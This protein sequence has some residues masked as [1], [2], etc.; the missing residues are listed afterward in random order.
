MKK[1]NFKKLSAQIMAGMLS[2]LMIGCNPTSTGKEEEST[3]EPKET[4]I[5]TQT[6]SRTEE[7]TF[8]I[9]HGSAY[10]HKVIGIQVRQDSLMTI[11]KVEKPNSHATVDVHFTDSGVPS[12][13]PESYSCEPKE[14][15]VEK[16][17]TLVTYKAGNLTYQTVFFAEPYEGGHFVKFGEDSKK[18]AVCSYFINSQGQVVLRGMRSFS[19]DFMIVYEDI[20]HFK[21]E[22]PTEVWI[23]RQPIVIPTGKKRI[24]TDLYGTDPKKWTDGEPAMEEIFDRS[25]FTDWEYETLAEG[26]TLPTKE[27]DTELETET[28]TESETETETETETESE[29]ETETEEETKVVAKVEPNAAPTEVPKPT[30]APTPVPKP[31]EAPK[32][33]AVPTPVPAPTATPVPTEAPKPTAV[34]TP[35]P[36]PVVVSNDPVELVDQEQAFMALVNA[37]RVARGKAPYVWDE[38]LYRVA[39]VRANELTTDF[40]HTSKFF[41]GNGNYHACLRSGMENIHMNEGIADNK[42]A[43]WAYKEMMASPGHEGV[44][45]AGDYSYAAVAIILTNHGVYTDFRAAGMSKTYMWNFYDQY[46]DEAVKDYMA[47]D[48]PYDLELYGEELL[49]YYKAN[50]MGK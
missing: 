38:G 20:E 34:P 10:E 18:Y 42:Q 35:V 13:D 11:G 40:Q 23:S 17:E 30:E 14:I 24:D 39:K 43:E 27:K 25:V 45:M 8:D 33:T 5:E 48:V 44:L 36:T 12:D 16:G 15:L 46:G 32:P 4:K 29:S 7:V 2:L 50:I 6:E 37:E 19:Y 21:N 49:N 1:K 26:E 3:K 22:T 28:E 31:T 41:D 47:W 9:P